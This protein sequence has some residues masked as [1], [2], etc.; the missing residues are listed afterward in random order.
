V[1]WFA[2]FAW[3]L[4]NATWVEREFTC[5][6]HAMNSASGDAM[7]LVGEMWDQVGR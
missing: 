3:S 6:K 5:I 7:S 1:T 4:T 2:I